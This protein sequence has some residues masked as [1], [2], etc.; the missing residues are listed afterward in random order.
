VEHIYKAIY[1]V[2]Y[3]ERVTAL[4]VSSILEYLEYIAVKIILKKSPKNEKL[5]NMYEAFL[6]SDVIIKT[7]IVQCTNRHSVECYIKYLC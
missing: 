2:L 1:K 3:N 7:L 6:C 4:F 5:E